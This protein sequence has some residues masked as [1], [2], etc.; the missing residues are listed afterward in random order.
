[1]SDSEIPSSSD[2][3][4]LRALR[5]ARL[6]L[7]EAERRRSEPVALVGMAC[8]FPGGRRLA[9]SLLAPAHSRGATRLC[10]LPAG[11][12]PGRR[13]RLAHRPGPPAPRRLPAGGRRL[14][15]RLFGIS[16]AEAT[17]LDPQQRLLLE[18]SWEALE[19]AGLDPRSLRGSAAGVWVGLSNA[20]YRKT[21]L[22]ARRRRARR[23]YPD[24]LGAQPRRR[25][26]LLRLRPARALDGARHGLLVVAGG[27]APRRGEPAGR[28][29]RPRPGRRRPGD[30]GARAGDGGSTA[31]PP[32]HRA[33][34]C[35]AF[36]AEADGFVRGE[37]AR[38]D[39]AVPAVRRA[40]GGATRCAP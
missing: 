13:R 20:D 25:P 17:G 36:D 26:P 35:R 29:V 6:K 34:I 31:W 9:G 15:P 8:R 18:V 40:S 38:R 19:D 16:P 3:R 7:E 5:E 12:E 14:R 11:R 4:L 2:G 24:R 21:Q 10:D 37:G 22:R 33:G 30:P 23:L 27:P 32:C 28:R 39:R 1:M